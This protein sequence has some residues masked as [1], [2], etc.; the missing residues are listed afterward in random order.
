MLIWAPQ[1]TMS[2]MGFSMTWKSP[3]RLPCESHTNPEVEY[4]FPGDIPDPH[5]S[6]WN[7]RLTGSSI[8]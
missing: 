7:D 1:N 2:T 4:K 3:A 8:P 6:D 5:T